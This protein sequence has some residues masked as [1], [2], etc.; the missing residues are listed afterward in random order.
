VKIK[1]EYAHHFLSHQGDFFTENLSWQAKQSILHTTVA[2]YGDCV[3]MYEDFTPNFEDKRADCIT[4]VHSLMLPFFTRN[5]MTVVPY[6]PY[7]SLFPQLK[8]K[9]KDRHFDAI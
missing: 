4:K 1:V 6:P 7:F 8:I 5:N 3:K 9:L 2:F